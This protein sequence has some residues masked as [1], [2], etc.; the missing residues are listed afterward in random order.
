MCRGRNLQNLQNHTHITYTSNSAITERPRD[1]CSSASRLNFRL[2]GYVSCQYLWTIR[3]GNGYTTT[4]PLE[5][6]TQRN[7]VADF[8]RLKLNFIQ[9]KQNNKKS[10]FGQP[11]EGLRGNVRTPSIARWK[12]H[13]NFLFVIIEL[14]R[15]LLRLR[16]Y[17]RKSVK[18]GVFRRRCVTLSVNF[19]GKRRRP[20]TT[21]GVRKLE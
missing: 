13:V 14:F 4:L 2:K 11:F 18:V 5:V 12:A 7:L 8:I 20:P 17:K 3:R 16:R 1:V 21:V 9:R 10:L 19:R 15:Y 6:F